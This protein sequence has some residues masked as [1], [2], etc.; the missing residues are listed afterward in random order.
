MSDANLDLARH[1]VADGERV[2]ADQD[3]R[4]AER[5]F[6]T[7][8]GHLGEA[9]DD[10][11]AAGELAEMAQIGL[12][13]VA[14]AGGDIRTADLRF[15][16]AQRL[17]P[18]GPDGLYW[19]GC[20]AAHDANYSRAEWLL[21]A[22][23]DRDAR[24]GKAYLQRAY[25]RLRRGRPELALPDLLTAAEHGVAS[26]NA[27]LLTAALLVAE[28]AERAADIAAGLP[29]SPA[30][31]A[32]L[33]M[34][35]FH[36]GRL[37]DAVAE[38]G[39]AI[40]ASSDDEAVLL[41][42]GL[43]CLQRG[44]HNACLAAWQ[45]L[46]GS[47]PHRD[48]LVA[49]ARYVLSVLPDNPRP[50]LAE[51]PDDPGGRAGRERLLTRCA[52][53]IAAVRRNDWPAAAAV[54]PGHVDGLPGEL[55]LLTA[56]AGALGGRRA[57]ATAQLAGAAARWPADHRISHAQAALLLHTLGSAEGAGEPDRAG[58]HS[59]IGAWVS[60]LHD[61]DFWARWRDKAAR[62]YN[63]P[64]SEDAIRAARTA[65]DELVERRLPSDDLTLLLVRE[66][67]A[68]AVLA[69]VGGLP[70]TDPDGRP[71]ICGPLRIAELGR[72][73]QFGEFLRG[74]PANDET[75]ELFW[76]FSAVGLAAARMAAGRTRAAALAALDLRCPSCA[77]NS[78]RTHPAM[79]S[80]P[81]LCEPACPEF[82]DRNPAFSTYRDKHDEL[83][84][85]SAALAAQTL[86]GVARAGITTSPMDLA[87]ART[88]W[89]GAVTLAKRFGRRDAVLR[90]VAD[91]ALGRSL[92]LSRRDDL[93][94]AIAVLDAVRGAIPARDTAE[95]DRV[96]GELS[97]L[98]NVRGI[99][100]FNKDPTQAGRAHADLVRAV[101]LRPD[102]P[103]PRLNLGIV[104]REMSYRVLHDYNLAESIRLQSESVN[105][106]EIGAAM[107]GTE[108]FHQELE[109][110]RLEL[111]QMLDDYGDQ[112]PDTE[113]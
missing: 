50:A 109:Q 43:A 5:A 40:A 103:V 59:C 73:R 62:R 31:A 30:A 89:R 86:L 25:V 6:R 100:V 54:L 71:L 68:A 82:D 106:F 16:R 96:T 97:L 20:T 113:L 19:A 4:V 52:A 108:R 63:C 112:P 8:L 72:T 87:D 13:R 7:A 32:I 14:L 67:A 47:H 33:G 76:Q 66:R 9:V 42:Y 37:D 104:L 23:L 74:Q 61:E 75:A 58:W 77:R 92:V 80:E 88:C 94:G 22:A 41:R 79:I 53:G 26:D 60:V 12:G 95:L 101:A 28:D 84:K 56:V 45:R 70:S 18:D 78:G 102:R 90:E 15:D 1:A 55:V 98:L 81:L 91:D 2:L 93:T 83:A 21:T 65:L 34:A 48:A 35:R 11:S 3:L 49:T 27:R 24:Y 85:A 17:R 51:A 111:E 107:H 99:R 29:P 36:Q 10:D 110:A 38:L 57:D 46:G 39:R 44:D 105:Q 69:R 64:L